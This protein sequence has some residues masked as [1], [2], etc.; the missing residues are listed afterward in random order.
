MPLPTLLRKGSLVLPKG[1]SSKEADLL[2]NSLAIDYI[3]TFIGDKCALRGKRAKNPPHGPGD[4]V[5]V[6]RSGTGSGKSTT[7][8]PELYLRLHDK[9]GRNIAI[10]QPRILTAIDIPR[11]I[12]NIPVFS[13]LKLEKNIGFQTGDY[14]RLPTESG[15]IFMTIGVLMNQLTV[16]DS[17]HFMQKYSFII[18]DEVHDR[19]INNDATQFL[20]K[21][22]LSENWQ[23]PVCPLLILMSATFE[24]S[25]FLNY[26]ECSD[27][28]FIDVKGETFPI[29]DNYPSYDVSNYVNYAFEKAIEIHLNHPDDYQNPMRDILIF[30][31]GGKDGA[32]LMEL[33]NNFNSQQC[34][35]DK[36]QYI[37]PILLT[38]ETFRKGGS[39]Y[40]NTFSKIDYIK[41][42][43]DESL[44]P[45]KLS[46]NAKINKE[47][48]KKTKKKTPKIVTPLRKVFIATNIAET[49]VTIDTLK[50]CIDTGFVSVSEFNPD[51]GCHLM[52]NKNVTKGA[53]IQRR[54]RVGRK[55]PGN[56]YPCY[57]KDTFNMLQT[58]QFSEIL[59]ADITQVLLNIFSREVGIQI[60][61]EPNH[62]SPD[63]IQA[64]ECG[65]LFQMHKISNQS[66]YKLDFDKPLNISALDFL[67]SP[68]ASSIQYS[69]EKLHCLGFID[70]KY[71]IT[72]FGYLA[73]QFQKLPVESIRMILA[74]YC[75]GANIMDLITI[76]ATLFIDKLFK[77]NYELRNPLNLSE[78]EAIFY[79]KIIFADEF[80][81][82][83]F[84]WNE[85]EKEVEKLG[86]SANLDNMEYVESLSNHKSK[87][88]SVKHKKKS[89]EKKKE[90]IKDI[91]SWC[92]N[93]GINYTGM[94]KLI[95]IRDEI[96][97]S[98]LKIGLN[99]YYN[100]LGLNVYNLTQIL[101][102]NFN[103]GLEEI[104]KLK[105]CILDGYRLNLAHKPPNSQGQYNLLY[106]QIPIMI[107]SSLVKPYIENQPSLPQY[108][109][110]SKINLSASRFNPSVYV[111]SN[112]GFTSVMDGFVDIDIN[113]LLE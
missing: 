108:I 43:I 79:N 31:R 61:D 67:E 48:L 7:I 27:S 65:Y 12:V 28:Q 98:M 90:T 52:L 50:Y 1:I 83:I 84:L 62:D 101:N 76:S 42:L 69:I 33:L 100:G 56:W 94:L 20:L 60:V 103:D 34:K 97:E 104:R 89:K 85:F 99:P 32:T 66:W 51:I 93:N 82:K 5:I 63:N 109:V 105:K 75:Y 70:S 26:Y 36:P 30:I 44:P 68:S 55:A 18:I 13:K 14:S 92:E 22:F 40:I 15:I 87:E 102:K 37:A 111:I 35:L 54:G 58:N 74:G 9:V 77:R 88:N 64:K 46:P 106:K 17:E 91:E 59:T 23:N 73:K 95:A 39:E 113:L 16:M 86:L 80:I 38:S 112:T 110:L 47:K 4:K 57:T 11:D 72:L 29:T 6:L 81:D 25:I 10:T 71:Q 53:A 107:T 49:G 3:M 19:D 24:P 21:K 8:A 45:S 96:I 41:V 78:N 2:N